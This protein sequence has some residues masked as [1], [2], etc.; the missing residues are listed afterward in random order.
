MAAAVV[1]AFSSV[2]YAQTYDK[3]LSENEMLRHRIESPQTHFEQHAKNS[4]DRYVA[5]QDEGRDHDD[6]GHDHFDDGH[7]HG[8][9]G[10]VSFDYV[11]PYESHSRGDHDAHGH[12][13]HTS[14][15]GYPFLHGIRTEIDFIERALEFEIARAEGADDGMVDEMEF[16][17]ELIWPINNRTI[18]ILGAPMAYLD[19]IA[20]PN[21]SGFGDMEI[22]LQFQ[23]FNGERDL[24]FFALFA[25]IPTGND[26][27]DLGNGHTVL[28]PAAMW[29]HDF[30][31]GTYFQSRFGWEIP[32]S[33][34]DVGSEFRYDM[35]LYHTLLSTECSDH[36]RWLTAAFEVNGVSAINGPDSGETTVD[37]TTGVRW[38]VR[39][40]DEVGIGWSFPVSGTQGFENQLIF[41]YR[42]HF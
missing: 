14:V 30:G 16:E 21:A 5:W 1:M 20:A 19:P 37:L 11:S 29:L 36:F 39:E 4:D 15:D 38:V 12:S 24:I 32:V 27:R 2:G 25:G 26:A 35:G 9:H 28:E 6:H 23:A 7:D 31:S 10:Q 18:I 13:G 42:R 8:Q 34:E 3:L 22:G 33:T 41:S 17:V 40:L